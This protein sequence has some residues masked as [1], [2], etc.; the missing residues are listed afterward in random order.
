MGDVRRYT[1]RTAI[2]EGVSG[3]AKRAAGIDN[4]VEQYT[5]APGDVAD[6]VHHFGF[7]RPLASFVDNGER[8]VEALGEPAGAH[9]AADVRGNNHHIL[10]A[11]VVGLDVTH[12]SW[13]AE[14]VVGRNV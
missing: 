2:E 4:V 1:C 12:H 5:M 14:Q 10:A 9:H 13:G 3:V 8:R 11:V 7:A 6:H